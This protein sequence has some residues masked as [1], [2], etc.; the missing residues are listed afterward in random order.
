[1]K[2]APKKCLTCVWATRV[3][4]DL[5]FCPFKGC[6]EKTLKRSRICARWKFLTRWMSGG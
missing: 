6:I 5:I 3:N 2:R 1:M 4:A